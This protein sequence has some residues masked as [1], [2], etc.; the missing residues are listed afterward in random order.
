MSD[1]NEAV[2]AKTIYSGLKNTIERKWYLAIDAR[3]KLM[4]L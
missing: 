2:R 3:S 1:P 4:F